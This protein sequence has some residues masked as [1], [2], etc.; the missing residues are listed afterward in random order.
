MSTPRWRASLRAAPVLLTLWS[1]PLSAQVS[2]RY[3]ERPP[4]AAGRTPSAALVGHFPVVY[5]AGASHE[6][7]FDPSGEEG[8]AVAGLLREMN[9]Y[10]DSLGL[11]VRLAG[12][13]GVRGSPPDVSFGCEQD[14]W[15]ECVER[16]DGEA[17]GRAG[18]RMRLAVL[19][20]S[21]SWAQAARASM[22]EAGVEAGLVLTL[23]VG[24]Y[25]LRQKGLRG[26]KVVEL[27]AGHV[28]RLPWLTSLETPVSVL[29]LTGARV[30]AR[31]RVT[32]I[33][34]E[35]LAVRRTRFELSALGAQELVTEEDVE[36]VRAGRRQ[37]LPGTPVL[38]QEA[39]RGLLAQLLR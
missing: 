35:G 36:A 14:P 26:D 12:G 21:G 10:L 37:D 34:A 6:A 15:G 28:V 16:D 23:E 32:R 25:L 30:D 8:G 3:L 13:D 24:Q 19:R 20:P 27:G 17:L 7:L 9:A 5:Q 38:W 4:W 39:L 31:G 11:T 2:D 18:T 1:V 29:Q 33:A 22:E